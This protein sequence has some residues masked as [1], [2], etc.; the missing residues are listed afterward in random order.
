MSKFRAPRSFTEKGLA[1]S[2]IE[3]ASVPG[4]FRCLHCSQPW[5]PCV[6]PGGRYPRGWWQCPHGCNAP[7]SASDP[8]GSR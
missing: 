7:N 8:K 3:E 5:S 1:K 6:L 4:W 2:G